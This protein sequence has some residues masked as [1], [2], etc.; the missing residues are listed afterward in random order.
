MVTAV[1]ISMDEL[2]LQ[3]NEVIKLKEK[4]QRT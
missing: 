4:M 3:V 2:K 1:G